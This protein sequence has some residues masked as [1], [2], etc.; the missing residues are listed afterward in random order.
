MTMNV[1]AAVRL[2]A[3]VTGAGEVQN[4]SSKI[5]DLKDNA[6]RVPGAMDGIERSLNQIKAA[7][8]LGIIGVGLREIGQAAISAAQSL[9]DA[10]VKLDKFRITAKF[11]IGGD[12]DNSYRYVVQQARSLG[13]ELDSTAQGYIKLS[14][15]ARGTSLEGAQTKNIFEAI[16]KASAVMGLSAEESGEAILA[17]GQMISK[18]KV[19]A[20]ELRGQLGERLPGAFQIAARSMGVT[21]Q[22]LD[23]MLQS[24]ELLAEDFL[25]RF[26][27]Q[28]KKE[29]GGSADEASNTMQ[30]ALNRAAT[31]WLQLK[32]T[33]VDAGLGD[34]IKG[35]LAIA[36]DA[37]TGFTQRIEVAKRKGESTTLAGLGAI[38]SQLNPVQ[39][40]SYQGQSLENQIKATQ[41]EIDNL[42]KNSVAFNTEAML[43]D[44]ESR[45]ARLKADL[46]LLQ[47]ADSNTGGMKTADQYDREKDAREAQARLNAAK[48]LN[49]DY[50]KTYQT[51][52]EKIA[53]E[54][55]EQQKVFD[56]GVISLEEFEK[57]KAAI[58]EKYK[59][60]EA[61]SK[62]K[63]LLAAQE[64]A[65][66]SLREQA[67]LGQSATVYEKTLWEIQ[68]GRYKDFSVA[69]KTELLTRA[70][71]I[72]TQRM[73]KDANKE[74]SEAL[75]EEGRVREQHLRAADDYVKNLE[76]TA[77]QTQ[78]TKGELDAFKDAQ[79]L[80]NHAALAGAEAYGLITDRIKKAR[81]ELARSK[82]DFAGGFR[83]GLEEYAASAGDLMKNVQQATNAAFR[84]MEDALVNFVMTGKMNFR[85]LANSII[86]DLVRIAIQQSIT[87]PLANS[88]FGAMGG[89]TGGSFMSWLGGKLTGA[90]ASGGPVAGGGTYLV[91]ENGPEIFSPKT[92]GTIIPNH[93]LGGGGSVSNS[94][95]VQISAEGGSSV[96]GNSEQLAQFG[97]HIGA[98]IDERLATAMRPGG[99]LSQQRR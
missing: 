65:L 30:G 20:E 82:N 66:Q 84:G 39:F 49:D 44:A 81:E 64:Q 5:N 55:A 52:S 6:K 68:K 71:I 18:G 75:R 40:F 41:L 62:A 69:A 26:A 36:D 27:D 37:M 16:A 92:S 73:E 17:V 57:R 42:R 35:Q 1:D 24:G 98:M 32:Q 79:I 23:K 58:R 8:Q 93:A 70:Q 45:L 94:V 13:L 46:A 19:S 76:D 59:D 56:S 12:T 90:R 85:S 29:L 97:R 67:D 2:G 31:S 22:E 33:I 89:S 38:A 43:S 72:D 3:T 78:M 50:L 7:G 63:Q 10:A 96:S 15:A 61:E 80:L 47:P 91:G 95:V 14:A 48:K 88:I 4:L 77:R 86:S 60:K 28:L 74:A 51:N 54:I 11:A 34:F 53:K 83:K 99:M 87:V 25:P 9:T 21:T